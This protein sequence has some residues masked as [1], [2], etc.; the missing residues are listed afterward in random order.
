MCE[1]IYPVC[2]LLVKKGGVEGGRE[3]RLI[4]VKLRA[5]TFW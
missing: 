2:L 4:L 3:G 1:I 5:G